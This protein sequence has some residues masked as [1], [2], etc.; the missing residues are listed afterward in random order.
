M[1]TNGVGWGKLYIAGEYAVVDPGHPAIIMATQQC[2]RATIEPSNQ[3]KLI[4]K[5]NKREISFD[6]LAVVDEYW[7]YALSALRVFYQWL[8]EKGIDYSFVTITIE[9]DLDSEDGRKLGLGSSGAVVAAII[10]GLTRYYH[11]SIDAYSQYKLCVIS[12]TQLQIGGSY[13]DLAAAVF[14]GVIRYTRF[15][16][17]DMNQSLSDLVVM[18][19]PKLSITYLE[20]PAGLH[21]VVGWTGIPA[22]TQNQVD[23]INAFKDEPMYDRLLGQA[24]Q[25]VDDMTKCHTALE[26]MKGIHR[27]RQW[28]KDLESLTHI[29]I[30]TPLIQ[31]FIE[32]CDKYQGRGKSSGAGGGDCAIAFFPHEV[33][34]NDILLSEGIMPLTISIAKREII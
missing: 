33:C 31:S 6:D 19:W 22:S 34:I 13:G 28:L 1:K 7:K 16:H 4:N 32:L 29:T 25:I 10:K 15:E 18:E 24:G 14:G 26:F 20:L 23:K 30:E 12:Q 5:N 11:L 2:I 8:E 17:F 27:Y 9:S 3:F 21:W